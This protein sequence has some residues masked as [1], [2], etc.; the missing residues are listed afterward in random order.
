MSL[1]ALGRGDEV[2]RRRVDRD[3]VVEEVGRLGDPARF[4]VVLLGEFLG[5]VLGTS[6]PSGNI[7]PLRRE[8][9][10]NGVIISLV[11]PYFQR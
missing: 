10:M 7:R 5:A 9:T 2:G 1:G 6:S 4:E 8:F 11:L 3:V